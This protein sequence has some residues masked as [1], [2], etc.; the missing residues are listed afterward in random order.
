[1]SDIQTALFA[2]LLELRN[3]EADIKHAYTALF[4]DTPYPGGRKAFHAFAREVKRS[5][6]AEVLLRGLVDAVAGEQEDPSELARSLGASAPHW[7]ERA[8]ALLREREDHD[9]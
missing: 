2:E 5:R 4:P 9:R 3:M 6:R 1:M 7:I 8:R